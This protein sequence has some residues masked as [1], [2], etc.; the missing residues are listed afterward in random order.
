MQRR[1]AL[2]AC[3]ARDHIACEIPVALHYNNAPFAV[4]MAT[5]CDLADLALG[6]SLSEALIADAGELQIDAIEDSVDGIAL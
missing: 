4:L 2:G 3:N 5:P 6:F 1:D